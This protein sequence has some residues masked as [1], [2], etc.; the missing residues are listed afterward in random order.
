MNEMTLKVGIAALAAFACTIFGVW[1]ATMTTLVVL[2]ALDIVSGWTRA[3]C[4]QQLSSKESFRGTFKKVLIF[5]AVAL[6]AQADTLV[7]TATTLR[8]AVVIF[9]CASEGLSV[10]ENMVAAGLPVPDVLRQALVQLNGKKMVVRPA[11]ATD[12]GQTE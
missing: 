7:G 8:D 10:L 11:A 9:Y 1:S 2:I 5:A 4:Q 12:T 3:F 6:A